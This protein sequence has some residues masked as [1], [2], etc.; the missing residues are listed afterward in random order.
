MTAAAAVSDSLLTRLKTLPDDSVKVNVL[1][2]LSDESMDDSSFLSYAKQALQLARTLGY[3]K[4]IADA[5]N[6][7]AGYY[8]DRGDLLH[9]MNLYRESLRIRE[10]IRDHA[11]IAQSFNNI[12][13]VYEKTG[14]LVSAIDYYLKSL[15]LREE[16]QDRAGIAT[17][18]NNI[19]LFY[20]KQGDVK[21]AFEYAQKSFQVREQS[22][23]KFGMA[24]SLN[25]MGYLLQEQGRLA[26]ALSC[27]ER[28]KG[29]YQSIGYKPGIAFTLHNIGWNMDRQGMKQ[30]ALDWYQRGLIL[31]EETG[32]KNMQAA[33]LQNIGVI[34]FEQNRLKE[35]EL[36]CYKSLVLARETGIPER[37]RNASETLS[38]IYRANSDYK[39]AYDMHVLFKLMNDSISNEEGRKSSLRKQMNYEFEKKE[40]EISLLNKDK[41]IR[42]KELERQLLLRNASILLSIFLLLT[43]YLFFSRARMN[44]RHARLLEEKN[45]LIEIEKEKAVRSEQYKTQFLS[46]MSHEI[47]TPLHAITGMINVLNQREPR[48]DQRLYLQ[49]MRKSAE[50]L[51][52]IINNIL[53]ISKIEAGKVSFESIAFSPAEA[54]ETVA[55]LLEANALDK[56]IQLH[57]ETTGLPEQVSGDP[58]RLSQVLINLTG[59]AIKFTTEGSVKI[60]CRV[61]DD[62][63]GSSDRIR[64]QFQVSDTG[65]GIPA[66]KLDKIFESFSQADEG[67]TRKFGGTGLGLT[68]SKQLI[69]LQGGKI[70]VS[71]VP[72]KGSVFTF[73]I[74]YSIVSAQPVFVA[75]Q[76]PDMTR[77][78]NSS[79]LIVEDNAYNRIVAKESLLSISKTMNIDEAE[80]GKLALDLMKKKHFDFVLMDLQMPEMDGYS[81]IKR[82]REHQ[83]E[84]LANTLFIALSANASADERSKCLEAGMHDYL[85][86]PFHPSELLHC[87]AVLQQRKV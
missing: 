15:K 7:I 60:S 5:T 82:I 30:E 65:T 17:Q 86:K 16:I 66:D 45:R 26:E 49:V 70:S 87:M 81:T 56:G 59:N 13:T 1:Y 3:N 72:G 22:G 55:S 4:G 33:T 43:G 78:Q 84:I 44:K 38:K 29:L 37:I 79:I 46:N 42:Q 63:A 75:D 54:I 64:L 58:V 85:S 74:P 6:N 71:S 12:G 8:Y 21:R 47:R 83:P 31:H 34:F 23:D 28:S 20:K 53:D 27:F 68:I 40:K 11:G 36:Y 80:N 14:D 9:A 25:N 18:H 2:Q 39:R 24:Q 57:T 19:S 76:V 50:N 51:I 69:E 52:G 67:I 48:D 32:D 35:A 73:V 10:E 62:G 61:V 77:L 41:E